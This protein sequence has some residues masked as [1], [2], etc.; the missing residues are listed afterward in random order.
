MDQNII[1][2][3]LIFGALALLLAVLYKTGGRD[4]LP[5]NANI[6][7]FMFVILFFSVIAGISIIKY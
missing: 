3:I 5:V 7:G 6:S 1:Y 2:I 4:N